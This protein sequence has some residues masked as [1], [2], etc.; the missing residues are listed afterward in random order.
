[1]R[2]L[3]I[4]AGIGGFSLGLEM[5]GMQCAGQVEIDDWCTRILEKHW[6]GIPRW[7]DVK[8]VD[9]S[10]LPA[11]E[12]VCGGYPC[13]P[14]SHAGQRRGQEDDRHI[15]PYILPLVAA[16]RPAWCL[17]E[18]VAGH[19]TLGLDRVLSDLEGIGYAS[20]PLV[21]PACAVDAPHRRDR[22]WIL[23][24]S[25]SARV[26]G[27]GQPVA[28]ASGFGLH[29]QRPQWTELKRGT[30]AW[31]NGGHVPDPDGDR[32]PNRVRRHGGGEG[33]IIKGQGQSPSG[34]CD[35]RWPVEPGVGR[36]AH[37]VPRRVDRIRGLGN[38]VVPRLVYEIGRAIMSATQSEGN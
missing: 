18:N 27:K 7:R 9:P 17:F 11:V 24:H 28:D 19:V 2:F 34:Y 13:Q 29:P 21:I 23:A 15:W 12:L 37:G 20:W 5:A 35:I 36:V 10:G 25:E 26:T 38:A 4:C 22:V 1:M 30:E 8:T 31:S 3:D 16:R 14:F 6:P 32:L 33:T